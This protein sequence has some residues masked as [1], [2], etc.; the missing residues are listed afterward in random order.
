MQEILERSNAT[1]SSPDLG[2]TKPRQP[3]THILST[4]PV[5]SSTS[6]IERAQNTALGVFL[7][8]VDR[9]SYGENRAVS[10]TLADKTQ[11]R[12]QNVHEVRDAI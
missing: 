9:W 10:G 4:G 5:V 7:V 6:G 12:E 8:S 1:L 11:G 2:P 3:N